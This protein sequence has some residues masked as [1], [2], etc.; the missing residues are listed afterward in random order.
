MGRVGGVGDAA[1]GL[2]V[3]MLGGAG[4]GLGGACPH[5]FGCRRILADFLRNVREVPPF[6][7]DGRGLRLIRQPLASRSAPNP[8]RVLVD[9]VTGNF[10]FQWHFYVCKIGYPS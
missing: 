10:L 6:N 3:D 1:V 9:V 4:H 8:C 5:G 7:R 2:L